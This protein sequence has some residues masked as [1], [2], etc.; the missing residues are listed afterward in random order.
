MSK[1]EN[2]RKACFDL[3]V[4]LMWEKDALTIDKVEADMRELQEMTEK[5]Y[6]IVKFYLEQIETLEGKHKIL[7]SAIKYKSSSPIG[8][9]L[10]NKT[11][12]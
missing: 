5:F 7:V 8:G 12:I 9:L 6:E 10:L 1:E 2:I 4:S 3:S 11:L